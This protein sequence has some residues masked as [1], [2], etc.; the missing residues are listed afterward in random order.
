[1]LRLKQ[2]ELAK[3]L[4]SAMANIRI[5]TSAFTDEGWAGSFYPADACRTY[6]SLSARITILI[7]KTIAIRSPTI[8]IFAD[9]IQTA[10]SLPTDA[11]ALDS[12]ISALES[13]IS[14]LES[15]VKEIGRA[16]CR[17]RV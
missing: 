11:S 3:H 16:S 9:L 5:G 1:M 7:P 14:A 17:E 8:M 10:S 15:E 12:S 6:S 13:A 4:E 2:E